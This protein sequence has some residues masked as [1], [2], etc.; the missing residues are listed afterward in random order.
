MAKL[1]IPAQRGHVR[2]ILQELFLLFDLMSGQNALFH[3][4]GVALCDRGS[5]D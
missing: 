2:P 3:S 4:L 1:T 5:G